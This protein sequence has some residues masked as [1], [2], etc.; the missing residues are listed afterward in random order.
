[1]IAVSA[2]GVHLFLVTTALLIGLK[3]MLSYV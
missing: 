2:L 1:V 3:G